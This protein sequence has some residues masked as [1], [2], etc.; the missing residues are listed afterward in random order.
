MCP[1]LSNRSINGV[2]LVDNEGKREFYSD[3]VVESVCPY[4]GVGCQTEVHVKDDKI[5]TL[6]VKMDLPMKIDYV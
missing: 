5:C 6:M 1:S 2:L 3:K 4:C